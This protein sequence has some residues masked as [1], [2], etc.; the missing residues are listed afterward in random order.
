MWKPIG[1]RAPS[2]QLHVSRVAR[3]KNEIGAMGYA[4]PCLLAAIHCPISHR[5]GTTAEL[6]LRA[7]GAAVKGLAAADIRS[8]HTR[9]VT[10]PHGNGTAERA[11][12]K[13]KA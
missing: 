6:C 13:V 8:K 12:K 11:T 9:N 1:G 10:L 3:A 7:A 5:K 4:K 2:M